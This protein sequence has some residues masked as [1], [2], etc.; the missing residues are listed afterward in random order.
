MEATLRLP[1]DIGYL[2]L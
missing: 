1:L 2:W